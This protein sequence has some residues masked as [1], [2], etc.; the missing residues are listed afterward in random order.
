M[1]SAVR[2]MCDDILM[3]RR[4]HGGRSPKKQSDSLGEQSKLARNK[5]NL[6]RRCSKAIGAYPSQRQL[7]QDEVQYVEWCLS[8]AALQEEIPHW[9]AGQSDPDSDSDSSRRLRGPAKLRRA[10]HVNQMKPEKT[11]VK[12]DMPKTMSD[13]TVEGKTPGGR[14]LCV[15]RDLN[16]DRVEVPATPRAMRPSLLEDAS[17]YS[18]VDA[19]ETTPERALRKMR[20]KIARKRAQTHR[21]EPEG[22]PQPKKPNRCRSASTAFQ[23]HRK[24]SN[25]FVGKKVHRK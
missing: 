18:R 2:K 7:N 24:Q 13:M 25:L 23:P 4:G 17:P 16:R 19:L 10:M 5:S 3:W 15:W 1:D 12:S 20:D 6:R 11:V 14:L 9:N 8:D 22:V 21:G